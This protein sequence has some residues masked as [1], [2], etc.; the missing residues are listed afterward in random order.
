MHE[1][2]SLSQLPPRP[3][4]ALPPAARAAGARPGPR[5]G[6]VPVF[7]VRVLWVVFTLLI[8]PV[9]AMWCLRLGSLASLGRRPSL[10][11]ISP[12]CQKCSLY[13][14]T[15]MNGFFKAMLPWYYA[16]LSPGPC[17]FDTCVGRPVDAAFLS[18]CSKFLHSWYR[19]HLSRSWP[20]REV[21]FIAPFSLVS[22]L[23]PLLQN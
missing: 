13:W 3:I 20:C 5:F 19:E 8:Q 4:S 18:A 14:G 15:G 12:I 21:R 17:S 2:S 6:L 9:G 22:A 16:Y 23:Y 1:G 11:S 7:A 10:T